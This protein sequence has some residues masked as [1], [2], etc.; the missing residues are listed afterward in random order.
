MGEI[1]DS[2]PGTLRQWAL[3]ADSISNLRCTH[4]QRQQRIDI[5]ISIV[6]DYSHITRPVWHR[7]LLFLLQQT[8]NHRLNFTH[9]E[10]RGMLNL[11]HDICLHVA[12]NYEAWWLQWVQHD[13]DESKPKT[14][15]KPVDEDPFKRFLDAMGEEEDDDSDDTKH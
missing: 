1:M 12:D 13:L 14:N 7:T 9:S 3:M 10:V 8:N 11:F 6:A 4:Y 2:V 15:A 5:L